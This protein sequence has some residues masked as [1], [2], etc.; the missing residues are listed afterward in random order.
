MS[1]TLPAFSKTPAF[2]VGT[3][4]TV[5]ALNAGQGAAVAIVE[6]TKA[7]EKPRTTTAASTDTGTQNDYNVDALATSPAVGIGI[8]NWSG[9]SAVTFNGFMGG[10]SGR[11][12]IIKN[13]TAAQTLTIA[14]EAGASTAANRCTGPA[15][16]LALG[17]KGC[18]Y[19][20]YDGVT[21]RWIV[22]VLNFGE[23]TVTL[24]GALV[25]ASAAIPKFKTASGSTGSI[26]SG[27]A[28][29]IFSISG[30]G[31]ASRFEVAAAINSTGNPTN[32]AAIATVVFDGSDG[33]VIAN[34]GG[35]LTITLSGT[36]VQVTQTTG[37]AASVNWVYTKLAA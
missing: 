15:A 1:V 31:V 6:G 27:V 26:T 13:S 3:S 24:I 37:G 17:P 8:L 28:T 36:N 21:S 23:G 7:I 12:L 29:T 25:A 2:D 34:N 19:L 35:G 4:A 14:T 5:D 22:E 32:Y 18:A 9:A 30:S 10:L 16:G 20:W 33:R 11:V